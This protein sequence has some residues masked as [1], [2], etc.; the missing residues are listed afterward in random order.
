MVVKR[1][2]PAATTEDRPSGSKERRLTKVAPHVKPV[3]SLPEDLSVP[4][5][6]LL[7]Y[8]MLIYGDNK[9]GKTSLAA[10]FPDAIFLMF[11][12]GGKALR[13]YQRSVGTWE[14]FLAYL[15][16]LETDTRFRTVVVDTV[17]MAYDRCFEYMCQ[18]LC[19]EHPHDEKDYGK[20]W[21]QIEN[22]FIKQISR[23][24]RLQKGVLFISHSVERETRTRGGEKFNRVEPSVS[25]QAARFLTAV[26][27]LW[28]Y[29]TYVG[30]DR[31]LI[32]RGDDYVSGGCRPVENFIAK[33]GQ[34]VQKIPMGG[35]AKTA[36][37]NLVRAFENRQPTADGKVLV[38]LRAQPA[39]LT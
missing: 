15:D 20:S 28:S 19:I 21:G 33:D 11:E 23:L 2:N 17:D 35:D 8:T 26:V 36:Y 31:V 16:L 13:I 5:S 37:E 4:S 32:L 9:I 27:D 10:Q 29:Y 7:D 39:K 34:P 1:V 18:K 14:E 30:L 12:A 3:V 38:V 24:L 6:A 22:E 25:N